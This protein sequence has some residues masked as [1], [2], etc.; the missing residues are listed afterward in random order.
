MKI[1]NVFWMVEENTFDQENAERIVSIV[2]RLGM[3]CVRFKTIPFDDVLSGLTQGDTKDRCVVLYGSINAVKYTQHRTNWVPGVW[4]DFKKLRC[5]NYLTELGD[6]SVHYQ[7]SFLP[8]IEIPRL[9]DWIFKTFADEQGR[10]FFR[11]DDNAKTFHGELVCKKRFQDWWEQV[12]IYNPPDNCLTM[13]SK[14]SHIFAEYRFIIA[15]K[16]VVTGCRS[17][18]NGEY[19]PNPTVYNDIKQ[20]AEFI[21]NNI[22]LHSDSIYIMDVAEIGKEDYRVIEVGSV[23]CAGL[24]RCELGKFVEKASEIAVRE[25]NE[26]VDFHKNF[27]CCL[28]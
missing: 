21:A 4:C 23:N 9:K 3:K 11:P 18:I 1:E 5:S 15:D 8:F 10:V 25:Y 14:P 17:H 12:L 20:Y 7:Y 28:Q 24:Y 26:Y 2:K 13:I 19:N 6:F 27:G 16:K 22:Y